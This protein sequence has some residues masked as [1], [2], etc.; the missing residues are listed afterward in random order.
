M[1]AFISYSRKNKAFVQKLATAF[2]KVNRLI[3]VD[4]E[5]IPLSAQW[6]QEIEEGI[7]NANAFIFIITPDSIISEICLKELE[8]A[9]KHNKRLVP[10]LH[11]EVK[12]EIPPEIAAVNWIFV[13]DSDNFEQ[14]FTS[15]LASLDTDLERVRRHTRLINRAVEWDKHQRDTSFLLRGNDLIHAQQWLSRSI[16]K[17]PEPTQLQTQ[18]I[19]QSARVESKKQRLKLAIVGIS[20]TIAIVL[21]LFAGS[22]WRL[23]EQ[24]RKRA[25][26]ERNRATFNHIQAL[27][28]LSEARLA[29][30]DELGALLAGVKAAK[31]MQDFSGMTHF[32]KETN[33]LNNNK[34]HDRKHWQYFSSLNKTYISQKEVTEL[35]KEVYEVLKEAVYETLERNRLELHEDRVQTVRFTPNIKGAHYLVSSSSDDTVRV[36]DRDGKPHIKKT[37]KHD[38]SVY[39]VSI[40][41][42]GQ[43][44]ATAS[45]D[46]SV[47]LW[48]F[49]G[50]LLD[51]L[52]YSAKMYD[53]SI[54]PDGHKIAAA[55]AHK[56]VILWE[57][58]H[59]QWQLNPKAKMEHTSSLQAI[60]FSHDG[61]TLASGSSDRLVKLWNVDNWTNKA[62]LKAHQDRVYAVSFSP[63]DKTLATASA[64]NTIRLWKIDNQ[65]LSKQNSLEL[66]EIL[67]IP[68]HT[69]WVFDVQYSP[70]GK[71]LASAS[72]SG[73]VKIWSRDGTLLKIFKNPGARMTSV[74][75]SSD[76][77]WL[78]SACG[79][80]T[81]KLYQLKESASV[82][83]IEGH[84]SG[85]KDV[86][87]SPINGRTL[88]STGTDGTV[89][90]WDSQ[91]YRLLD[92]LK[93]N[94]STRDVDYV[95]SHLL[96][97]A[98]YENTIQFWRLQQQ[99]NQKLTG[100][101][102]YNLE[103][104]GHLKSIAFNSRKNWLASTQSNNIQLWTLQLEGTQ[105]QVTKQGKSLKGHQ[106][107]VNAISFSPDGN[108][109]ASGSSD[110]TA[111]LWYFDDRPSQI[112]KGHR[113][114]INNIGFSHDSQYLATASSDHTI[115]LWRVADGT[116]LATTVAEDIHK[117][118]VWDV[119]FAP[120]KVLSENY[121]L[122]VSGGA[123]NVVKLWHYYPEENSITLIRTLRG[124]QGW[125]R[126]A[127]FSSDGQYI[128]SASADKTVRFWKLKQFNQKN[129]K[130]NINELLQKGCKLLSNYLEHN[131][132]LKERDRKVCKS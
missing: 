64:D 19:I 28:S 55:S 100:I 38:G 87:M 88:A 31:H 34:I 60:S 109:L 116:L 105:I 10:L 101:R 40:S 71:V 20:L 127:G 61:K 82:R 48:N 92:T 126:S 66:T 81:I 25:E 120:H 44:F 47:K 33:E 86:D 57:K 58:K 15:L 98:T 99:A 8:H 97:L 32:Q 95:N 41:A 65:T 29:T 49:E 9:L 35:N 90:I 45:A 5:G 51:T 125:I 42:D 46:K 122:L 124:H 108:V 110:H 1:E 62:I 69:N 13:R 93:T 89:R 67:K 111:I 59:G 102:I 68:A 54:S 115:K 129:L 96:A 73:T 3:W 36:W 21:A 106:K 14:A 103:T 77:K 131:T 107:T 85:L 56:H 112:L 6:W 80:N 94:I 118:W 121:Y 63:D 22:Q 53:V 84:T 12:G 123:D 70:D 23:A 74:S 117:D 11:Q 128:V 91:T 76:G 27:T 39:G 18:Y 114:W 24:E 79:D 2:E 37:L 52:K 104:K 4:W 113:S 7:E 130:S 16:E 78:A 132:K 119:S 83:I 43:F 26:Q 72:A 17:P 50:E 30:Y 75:F